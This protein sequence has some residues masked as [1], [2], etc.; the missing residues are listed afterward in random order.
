MALAVDPKTSTRP[1]DR[2]ALTVD[3]FRD[4]LGFLFAGA[5]HAPQARNASRILI[6][7]AHYFLVFHI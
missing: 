5:G 1:S 6:S 3:E 2:G 7:A 4:I